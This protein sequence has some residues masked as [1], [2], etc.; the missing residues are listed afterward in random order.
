MNEEVK[1]LN[2]IIFVDE[3]TNYTTILIKTFFVF[4]YAVWHFNAN[5]IIKTD[6]DAF[7]NVPATIAMLKA[8]QPLG[9]LW[10]CLITWHDY[11]AWLLC[12][13]A[14]TPTQDLC[15]TPT[16]TNERLYIGT[17]A[18][19]GPVHLDPEHRWQN[20]EFFNHT[21]LEKYPNYMMGGGY[22]VS[23][24]VAAALVSLHAQVGLKFTP[25]EDAT[26]GF[27]LSPMDLRQVDHPKIYAWGNPCCFRRILRF[28]SC[29]LCVGVVRALATTRHACTAQ[30]SKQPGMLRRLVQPWFR[31]DLC[32]DDP[33]LILHKLDTP[34][35]MRLMGKVVEE[36]IAARDAQTTT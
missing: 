15:M 14:M 18:R 20:M 6:D 8:R 17:M 11:A 7:I 26:F 19:G 25:I 4:Q 10:T 16:C 33:W 31:K 23:G 35:K 27:W 1:T 34:E 3:S 30:P 22:V 29:T 12:T 24:D 5:F 28:K 2:D 36:C 32:S 21:G 13:T 9:I